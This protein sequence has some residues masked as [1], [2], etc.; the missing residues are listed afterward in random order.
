VGNAAE[1]NP[2]MVLKHAFCLRIWRL[3]PEICRITYDLIINPL[4]F[5][6]FNQLFGFAHLVFDMGVFA[7]DSR[8][9]TAVVSEAGSNGPA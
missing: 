5:L 9:R 8:I 1:G 6:V 3:L 7:F 2:E 4:R